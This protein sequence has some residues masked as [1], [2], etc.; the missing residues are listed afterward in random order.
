[1]KPRYEKSYA[2]VIGIDDFKNAPPLATARLGAEA[3]AHVL[4]DRYSF[5]NVVTLYDSDATKVNIE[6]AHAGLRRQM[7]L[8]DRFVVYVAGHG[9][10][11]E[12]QVRSEGFVVAH[13]SD[14][15]AGFRLIKMRDLVDPNFTRAKHAF[16][17]L[18]T[19]HSGFAV[20]YEAPRAVI[21]PP[22]DPRLAMKQ[23]LTRKAYQV[24]ASSNPLETATDAPLFE[25]H[26][27]FTGYLLRA[28]GGEDD[29]A[30][31]PVNNLLTAGCDDGS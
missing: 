6:D 11:L 19:C 13:D 29:T 7:Q 10:G 27:P 2:L 14:P 22:P 8:N 28:L 24:L 26:T 12:G 3:V 25:G 20:A 21:K 4:A 5:D 16:V 1:M 18:D 23:F 30:R 31:S 9:V 17:I 15:G